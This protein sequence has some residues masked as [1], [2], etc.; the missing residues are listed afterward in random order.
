MVVL[1]SSLT[2]VPGFITAMIVVFAV[3][4][5]GYFT[6]RT[7]SAKAAT[8]RVGDAKDETDH[9]RN[10]FL[11]EKARAESLNEQID[12]HRAAKHQALTELAA[13]RLK[14][15]LSGLMKQ[16]G[17]AFTS[18]NRRLDSSLEIQEAQTEALHAITR[19][20]ESLDRKEHGA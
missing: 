11:A 20:L 2:Q 1:G 16:M 6:V 17:D 19:R 12:Q 8:Q 14:T 18:V 10:S 3:I 9:W 4:V 5:T 15:D 7:E 13:E